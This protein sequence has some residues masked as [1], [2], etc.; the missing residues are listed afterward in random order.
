MIELPPTTCQL[1]RIEYGSEAMSRLAP[2][3]LWRNEVLEPGGVYYVGDYFPTGT[4]R[5]D[6]KFFY[7]ETHQRWRMN[8]GRDEYAKTT[9]DMRRQFPAFATAVTQDRVDCR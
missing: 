1:E 3:R 7:N 2:F 6:Y 8:P 5:T 4:S 9:A